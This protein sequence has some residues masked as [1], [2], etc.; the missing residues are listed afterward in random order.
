MEFTVFVYESGLVFYDVPWVVEENE[1]DVAERRNAWRE[2]LGSAVKPLH[3]QAAFHQGVV[4][5]YRPRI[6]GRMIDGRYVWEDDPKWYEEGEYPP[7]IGREAS[8]SSP[9]RTTDDTDVAEDDDVTE[10]VTTP[11]VLQETQ[12]GGQSESDFHHTITTCIATITRWKLW[13]LFRLV[14]AELEGRGVLA[15]VRKMSSK[16]LESDLESISPTPLWKWLFISE[17]GI[18]ESVVLF[19]T[20]ADFCSA[21]LKAKYFPTIDKF[22][23]ELAALDKAESYLLNPEHRSSGEKYRGWLRKLWDSLVAYT[24]QSGIELAMSEAELSFPTPITD[25]HQTADD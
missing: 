5:T 24:R 17:M 8:T 13:R 23:R 12:E 2:T 19:D 21:S 15:D 18:R 11:S 9:S 1:Q 7:V 10:K 3:G 22:R 4:G 14:R 25:V 6:R 16:A 20:V